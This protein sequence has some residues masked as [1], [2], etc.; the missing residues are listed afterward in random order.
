MKTAEIAQLNSQRDD[1]VSCQKHLLLEM[2]G[3]IPSGLAAGGGVNGKQQ[4]RLVVHKRG[5]GFALLQKAIYVTG[6]GSL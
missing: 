3:V 2:A 5:D 4:A 6:R 1:F